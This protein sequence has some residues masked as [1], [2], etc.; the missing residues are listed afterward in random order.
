MTLTAPGRRVL[1][2]SYAFPPSMEVGAQACA[3]LVRY[4]PLYG[5]EPVVLTVSERFVADT[6]VWIAN[7]FP[8]PIARAPMLPH[9]LWLYRR[10]RG[11]R[12]VPAA[13]ARAGSR[14]RFA[15]LR[16]LVLSSLLTPDAY[17]GW[18]LPAVLRG[19]REIRRSGIERIF[20]S[21]PPWTSHLVAMTLARLTGRP[22]VAHFRD[23]WMQV[24]WRKPVNRLTIGLE[25][26]LEAM[27]MANATSVVCVTERHTAALR[28]MYPR[29]AGKFLTVPNGYDE[30]DWAGLSRSEAADRPDRRFVVVYAGTLYD[31]R[32]PLPLLRALRQL[33][34]AGEIPEERI[35]I[36]ILGWCEEIEGRPIR[37]VLAES[38]MAHVVQL[39]G[40]VSRR[41]ALQRIL[42]AD[43]LLL[44]AEEQ[45][46]QIPGKAYE[47]LRAGRPIL[48]L[49][50]QG[51]VADLLRETGGA[52]VCEPT[53]VAGIRTGLL[54]TFRTWQAGKPP[55][56][57]DPAMVRAVQ[58]ERLAGRVVETF[59]AE[60]A[61]V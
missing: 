57:P 2:V 28:R 25:R 18:F 17:T 32:N 54:Q 35:R 3:Q 30:A 16:H 12:T 19:L 33:I 45:P 4:F 56:A 61:R 5:W 46:Q 14:T 24:A 40:L 21:G 15:G 49:T 29:H 1:V 51:A 8:G 43:L 59:D 47:Y 34:D 52:V 44:L 31:H 20:S 42:D 50:G 53:D 10:M 37:D 11:L 60:L 22:W 48:A 36:D 23:P 41:A 26:R 55:A 58:R 13:P 39:P 38:G 6:D 27:V 7:R 9:P